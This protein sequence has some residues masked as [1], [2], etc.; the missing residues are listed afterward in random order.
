MAAVGLAEE[1]AKTGR[2]RSHWG[3]LTG[4]ISPTALWLI[5]FIVIPYAI[6]FLYAIWRTNYVEVLH[7]PTLENLRRLVTDPVVRSVAIR[8]AVIATIVTMTT[9]AGALP[10]AYLAAFHV[11]HKALFVFAIVLP[12]WVSYIVRAY[13]W[14]IIL[15]EHGILNELLMSVHLVDKPVTAFL[16]SPMAV[17]ITLTHVYLAFMFVPLYSVL[18]ALP[19]NLVL[20]AG[21]LYANPF[22]R[23]M[24]VTLPLATPGIA[25]GV[26]FVFPLTF[27]DYIAPNLVGGPRGIMIANL[28]QT[29]FGATFNWPFG[30][31]IALGIL[32]TV[33]LVIRLMEMWRGVDEVKLV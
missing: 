22:R 30:A 19:K 3:M 9:L 27:G 23:F 1:V 33:L 6:M 17:I 15:G 2:R 25:A 7:T 12:M 5:A 8:S 13:A 21:D 29:E 28:V 10:L 16:F 11:K 32:V 4:F 26:M 18:E 31:A 24:R 14:R 20:A